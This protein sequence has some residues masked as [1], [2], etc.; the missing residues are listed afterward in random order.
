MKYI[1]SLLLLPLLTACIATGR[2]SQY[3]DSAP[4][5]PP[6]QLEMADANITDEPVGRG[7][8]PYRIKGIDYTPQTKRQA[9]S[10]IGTASWYGKKFHGH[11][12]SNGEV[13]DM[14]GMSAAHKTLPL[15][16]FVKV[17]NLANQ[18]STI[19]RV[20]DR[21]PFHGDRIIDLSYSAAYKLGVFHTG[22]AKVKIEVLLPEQA[23]QYQV[24]LSGFT[25]LEQ[26]ENSAKAV[27]LL[28]HKDARA[29]T[30][31]NKHVIL[32]GPYPTKVKA[33][34]VIEKVQPLG[35]ARATIQVLS[36]PR[37]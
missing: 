17:T 16:S 22:T 25:S 20:N 34:Q 4:V 29:R 10:Q 2:Y 7:N 3:S 1:L 24:T 27:A 33:Q 31:N 15:P 32:L 21:G 6:T 18:K 26:A 37:R 13:Y 30:I 12:T 36:K 28:L 8:R 9:F 11:L 23:K 5:R 14:Y 35:F 19:V